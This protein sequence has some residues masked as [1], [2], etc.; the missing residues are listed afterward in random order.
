MIDELSGHISF[1][2]GWL[3]VEIKVIGTSR[4]H[5]HI[6]EIIIAKKRNPG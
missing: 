5:D 2:Q 4:E 3:V 6:L 1:Q